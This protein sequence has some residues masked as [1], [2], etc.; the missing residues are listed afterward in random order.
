MTAQ[1]SVQWRHLNPNAQS[2]Y[3]QLFVKATRIRA[4]VLYGL[5]VND[6]DPMTVAEIAAD[7]G[8]APE[9][10]QEAIAMASLS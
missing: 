7:Y 10:V 4:R 2:F 3:R 5:Y 9:A 6:E 1:T 8:L